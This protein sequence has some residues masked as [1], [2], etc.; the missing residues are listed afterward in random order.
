MIKTLFPYSEPT[1]TELDSYFHIK[2]FIISLPV[3]FL[4][5]IFSILYLEFNFLGFKRPESAAAQQIAFDK[6]SSK[7]ALEAVGKELPAFSVHMILTLVLY[8]GSCIG[9]VVGSFLNPEINDK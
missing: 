6:E 2:Y 3:S 9:L 7:A 1:L 8:L 4:L 5:L